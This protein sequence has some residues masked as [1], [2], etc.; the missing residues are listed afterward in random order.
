MQR[1]S[2]QRESMQ[3]IILALLTVLLG[4]VCLSGNL[5][6]QA[7][8]TITVVI[9]G[10]VSDAVTKRALAADISYVRLSEEGDG[11]PQ[12][13]TIDPATGQYRVGMAAG[14]QY[15]LTASATAFAPK[16]KRIDLRNAEPEMALTVNF[17]LERDASAR[18]VEPA[19]PFGTLVTVVYFKGNSVDLTDASK[20]ELDRLLRVLRANPNVRLWVHGHADAKASFDAN[21]RLGE[22]RTQAVRAYLIANDI[23]PFRLPS[24]SYGNTRMMTTFPEDRYLNDR[25]EF[26]L[27]KQ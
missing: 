7:D 22:L 10:K 27:A 14:A 13:V 18:R 25:V 1:E 16:A 9:T 6:A 8:S 17:A 19:D 11:E 5:M 24:I 20:G 15:R 26:H 23:A 21:L 4:G 3:K 2:M 12:P